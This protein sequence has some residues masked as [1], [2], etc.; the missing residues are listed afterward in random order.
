V[1]KIPALLQTAAGPI[2][3]AFFAEWL[4]EHANPAWHRILYQGTSLL[5]PQLPQNE[6]GLQPR[7]EGAL[8]ESATTTG[9]ADPLNLMREPSEYA[10]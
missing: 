5:V 4:G 6:M 7:P 3:F 10:S 8:V 2:H 9:H 1:T